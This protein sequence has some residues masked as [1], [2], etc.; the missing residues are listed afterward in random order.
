MRLISHKFSD[1][2][3][4]DVRKGDAEASN[5]GNYT[6]IHSRCIEVKWQSVNSLSQIK[7]VIFKATAEFLPGNGN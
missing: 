1:L 2:N 4:L 7:M 3:N 5:A 6:Q